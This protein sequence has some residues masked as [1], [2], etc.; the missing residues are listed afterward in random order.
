M[1][2]CINPI[3]TPRPTDWAEN[4]QAGQTWP[5]GERDRLF[6][7]ANDMQDAQRLFAAMTIDDIRDAVLPA[8]PKLGMENCD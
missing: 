1:E 3:R 6:F 4:S 8:H 5:M 2:G 7:A